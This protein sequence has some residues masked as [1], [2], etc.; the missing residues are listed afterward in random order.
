MD[1]IKLGKPT[2]FMK[3]LL[4]SKKMTQLIEQLKEK[5]E[6]LIMD[7]PGVIETDYTI[8]L[9]AMTALHIFIIGSSVVSK[10]VVNESL[11]DLAIA[12]LKP[13]G[14]ILNRVSPIYIEDTRIKLETERTKLHFW[15]KIFGR[16]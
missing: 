2:P 5:Y 16:E 11:R 9:V 4:K 14:L 10:N 7:T 6:I 12:G 15:K 13:S 8:N 1:R 3:E